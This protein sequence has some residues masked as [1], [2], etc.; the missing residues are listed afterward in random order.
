MVSEQPVITVVGLGPGDP[1]MV[2][3]AAWQ[4]LCD[5][6]ELW[7]RTSRH[8]T[9]AA[10]PAARQWQSFDAVYEAAASFADVY[11][12]IV[13][14]VCARAQQ[15]G[16]LTY[17][18]PG[19]PLVAEATT[20][21]ILAQAAAL[22]ITVRII[23]GVSFI[24]G[25]CE[26]LGCDPLDPG[27]QL[28]DA[29]ELRAAP[30]S[31]GTTWADHH[32]HA[33]YV[34]P[35]APFPLQPTRPALIGQLFS[36]AVASDV[37]LTLLERYPADHTVRLVRAAGV[38]D[39]QRVVACRLDELDHRDDF[40]HLTSLYVPALDPLA[41][42]RG[43]DGPA[44][45][46]ARLFGPAGCPWDHEQ[47]HRSLRAA[48][49]EE[50]YEVLEALDGDDPAALAE[51]LGDVLLQV[52]MHAEIGR[53]SQ[54]FEL[55]DVTAALATKLIR[56]H[57]H[58]FGDAAGGDPAA[59]VRAWEAIK[60]EE[61][62]AAG[63]AARRP[64]DGIP[65]GLPAL[66]LAQ[67]V[68]R[69]AVRAGLIDAHAAAGRQQV[70]TA[71]AAW[72]AAASADT[73]GDVLFALATLAQQLGLDAESALREAARRVRADHRAARDSSRE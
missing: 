27:L 15:R 60:R 69:R 14:Q 12:T 26:A 9:L 33:P 48:L 19:H 39:R 24:E 43:L 23:G 7:V 41:D 18:V 34:A 45:V 61:R 6:D 31:A 20:R 4:A 71:L 37:K 64:F 73:L 25:C 2:T 28:I 13:A 10:L 1:G 57:P 36:R 51:E 16:G 56:R 42:V 54:A 47:T 59:I 53:Q 68:A 62:A 40:D 32:G 72:H 55:A 35:W 21:G 8:P 46:V 49:L 17:A 5:A 38:A 11:A 3:R 70:D 30:A 50:T 65:P 58:V 22:R 52:L 29:L 66:A 44:T 67:Q 63:Q